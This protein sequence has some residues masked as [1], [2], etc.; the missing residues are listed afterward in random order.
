MRHCLGTY[1]SLGKETLCELWLSRA[2]KVIFNN[3]L[4]M[5]TWKL[6]VF[7]GLVSHM[8]YLL[9][10]MFQQINAL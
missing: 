5:S 4:Q 1:R 9:W 10:V 8:F 3:V 7:T 6:L 2:P